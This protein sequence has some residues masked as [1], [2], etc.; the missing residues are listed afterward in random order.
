[1]RHYVLEICSLPAALKRCTIVQ[2]CPVHHVAIVPVIVVLPSELQP[3]V[4]EHLP[5]MVD[6]LIVYV[7][8]YSMF[9]MACE[10]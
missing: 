6:G 10:L 2:L 3:L 7:N 9:N 5:Q 4:P 1:M 8:G